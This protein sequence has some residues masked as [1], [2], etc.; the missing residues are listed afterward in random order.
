M[1]FIAAAASSLVTFVIATQGCSSESNKPPSGTSGTGGMTTHE[2]AGLDGETDAAIKD[3]AAIDAAMDAESDAAMD[4]E[5][6]AEA[7]AAIDA[8]DDA[9]SDA[10]ID[11]GGDAAPL[12]CEP[13]M[14][15][16]ACDKCVYEQCCSE[17]LACAPGTPC[18]ALWTCART[19]GCLDPQASD[20]DTCAVAACPAEA[21]EPA[22]TSIEAL[23]TCIR[24][25]CSTICGG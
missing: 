5:D 9:E 16:T 10:A 2:D 4:A 19:A 18:D 22:V 6:D 7:D 11:A 21:T 24:S 15:E 17:A 8:E 13:G 3:D 25:R 12:T 1:R 23:A 20:F 14:G